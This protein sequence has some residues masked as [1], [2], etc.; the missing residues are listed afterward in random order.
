MPTIL[1]EGGPRWTGSDAPDYGTVMSS[2]SGQRGPVPEGGWSSLAATLLGA[3]TCVFGVQF[4]RL[5]VVALSVN[6]VQIAELS[7]VLVGVMGLAV[8]GLGFLAPAARALLGRSAVPVVLGGLGLLRIAEQLSSSLPVDLALSIAGTVVFLWS[9]PLMLRS[10]LGAGPAASGPHTA[11]AL[12]LALSIDTAV[13]GAFGTIDLS[14]AGGAAAHVVTAVMVAAQWTLLAIAAP[15]RTP[16][17][18]RA[19]AGASWGA[20]C[21]IFGPVLVLQFL[22]FQNVAWQTVAIGWPQP[23]VLAWVL[24]SNLAGLVVALWLA[25]RRKP[26][27]ASV[28]ALLGGVLIASV[29]AEWTGTLAAIAVPVGQGASAALLVSAARPGSAATRARSGATPSAWT[30]VGM[31]A[32]LVLLF[33]HYAQYDIAIPLPPGI[34]RPLSALLVALAAL[35]A[36]MT[37]SPAPVLV[38][39]SAAIPALLLLA[40]PAVQLATWN[41]VRAGSGTGFPVRVMTYN[42]H[43]GFDAYGRHGME[44]IAQ[45]I[46]DEDPDVVAL[47]EVSRGWLING[48]VDTLVWLSRRLGMAYAFGPAAD[49]VWGNA[50]LS[51]LPIRRAGNHLMP[52]NDDIVMD[53]GFM[54]IEIDVG[55][56]EVLAVLATHFHHEEE[57]SVHRMPQTRAILEAVE[58]HNTVL[59]GDLNAL[60]DHPEIVLIADAGFVDAFAAAGPPGDGFTWPTDELEQRID[61]VWTSPDLTVTDFSLPMSTASDHL[62]IAVTVD[63]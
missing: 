60:P 24:V 25:R 10:L 33:V 12:L 30:T 40:V 18:G 39:H 34:V 7:S 14:W 63:R 15:A 2:R 32:L 6:L 9:L 46:E 43:Q 45:V 16:K 21:L 56:G 62:A 55:G 58:A 4:L 13:R 57:D 44:A 19:A 59:L 5:L 28:P 35:R 23:A 42:I 26:L 49:P 53:R 8:F 36:G 29:A 54:T 22:T 3:L 20:R 48:S 11:V 37:G 17:P 31:L 38:A 27:H 47:Q 52:N 51:R 50:V 1:R 61:Y 41:E